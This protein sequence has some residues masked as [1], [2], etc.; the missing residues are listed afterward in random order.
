MFDKKIIYISYK[1][2]SGNYI[3][4]SYILNIKD[5][6]IIDNL[7]RA[8]DSKVTIFKY[9]YGD[10]E[11]IYEG[12]SKI[13]NDRV[14]TMYRIYDYQLNSNKYNSINIILYSLKNMLFTIDNLIINKKRTGIILNKELPFKTFEKCLNI[15]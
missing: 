9:S 1:G 11:I 5:I 14:A 15:Y 4:I 7:T 2:N 6:K 13:L 8:T 3:D 12:F 10:Y